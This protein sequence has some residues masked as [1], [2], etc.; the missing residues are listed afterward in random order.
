MAGTLLTTPNKSGVLSGAL[1]VYLHIKNEYIPPCL[2]IGIAN[3]LF[4]VLWAWLSKLTVVS[5]LLEVHLY[6]KNQENPKNYLWEIADLLS[7]IL[8]RC[9]G[10]PN[11]SRKERLRQL[12]ENIDVYKTNFIRG[13]LHEILHVIESC[14]WIGWEHFG[15][16][17][18]NQN[19]A[20]YGVSA[21]IWTL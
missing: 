5:I 2:S 19:F 12:V 17:L 9:S 11:H 7:Y 3:F 15:P 14:N 6:L 20:R 16:L 21:E 10:A 4:R 18:K 8:W 13:F 1:E